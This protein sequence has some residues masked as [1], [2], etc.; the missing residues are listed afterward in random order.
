MAQAAVVGI[1][2]ELKGSLPCAFYVPKYDVSDHIKI[3]QELIEM[4]RKEVG[5][6]AAF[7]FAF[8]VPELPRTRSGKTPRKSISDLA[9]GKN[10]KVSTFS[11]KNILGYRLH[12][13]RLNTNLMT[14]TYRVPN[15]QNLGF[16]CFFHEEVSLN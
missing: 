3:H 8:A 14:V 2:D 7:R 10:I 11:G 1:N 9:V 5:A 16:G 4:V 13:N 6:V 15:S 12:T